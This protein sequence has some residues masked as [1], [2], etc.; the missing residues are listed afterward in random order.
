MCPGN[1]SGYYIPEGVDSRKGG[2]DVLIDEETKK[3]RLK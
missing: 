3:L 1:A 2:L